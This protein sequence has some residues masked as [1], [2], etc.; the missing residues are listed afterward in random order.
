MPQAKS[1]RPGVLKGGDKGVVHGHLRLEPSQA[2]VKIL[3]SPEHYQVPAELEARV[4]G[5]ECPPRGA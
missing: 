1:A 3:L 4:S 2:Q 5:Q